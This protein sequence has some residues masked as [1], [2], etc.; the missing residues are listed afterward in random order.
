MWQELERWSAAAALVRFSGGGGSAGT[1]SAVTLESADKREL[2]RWGHG[3]G[4]LPEALAAP[5]WAR[6]ALF[7]GHPPMN[8]LIMWDVREREVMVA[9]K[10]G[11]EDYVEV[12]IPRPLSRVS[13][14]VTDHDVSRDTSPPVAADAPPD[15][16][17]Q[18]CG[19]AIAV[20][21]R[22][23]AMF[24]SKLCRQAASRSRL[25]ERSG[26]ASL[27]AP[28]H[29]A[30]CSESMPAGVRPEARYCSKRCRQAASRARLAGQTRPP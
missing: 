18:R 23:Q 20:R 9:G 1:I 7:R 25:R 29:C 10:R 16:S 5:L 12:L 2:A 3:E 17:C 22:P 13:A 28:E 21:A 30:W 24:C 15:R 6:Y 19:A 26:R 11:D 8:G 4:E 14:S 27:R